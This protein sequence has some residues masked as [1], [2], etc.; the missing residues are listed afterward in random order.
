[1]QPEDLAVELWCSNGPGTGLAHNVGSGFLLSMGS[2]AWLITAAHNVEER[3]SAF[4][5]AFDRP[6]VTIMCPSPGGGR[7]GRGIDLRDGRAV[8][9]AQVAGVRIDFL[10]I[11]V[12]TSD[13]PAGVELLEAEVALQL[14]PVA[15][16]PPTSFQMT[17]AF[18]LSDKAGEDQVVLIGYPGPLGS[19]SVEIVQGVT[20]SAFPRIHTCAFSFSPG[21]RNGF[22]GGPVFQRTSAEHG[23]LLGVY[24]HQGDTILS[25]VLPEGEDLR[26]TVR[27]GHGTSIGVAIA[28][29]GNP[30]L[31]G[32]QTI[33]LPPAERWLM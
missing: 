7:S 9:Y 16:A 13:L 18:G 17:T 29:C 33:D 30:A 4:A 28:V 19:G 12:S 20:H 11:A 22:S 3:E 26:A 10:A 24:T 6:I 14:P 8:R 27:A 25:L 5:G 21:G 2:Q 31:L 1:M 23:R 32:V 15:S